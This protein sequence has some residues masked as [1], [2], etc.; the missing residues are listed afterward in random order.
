MGKRKWEGW[1]E[2]LGL[3]HWSSYHIR[4]FEPLVVCWLWHLLPVPPSPSWPPGTAVLITLSYPR[5]APW[6]DIPRAP[7]VIPPKLSPPQNISQML[8]LCGARTGAPQRFPPLLARFLS[9]SPPHPH[10]AGA[11]AP[12]T[13]A[14]A[15]VLSGLCPTFPLPPPLWASLRAALLGAAVDSDFHQDFDN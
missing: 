3:I 6:Q 5:E 4:G 9:I 13:A 8:T 12:Q 10:L 11:G 2:A 15:R 14:V 1:V 7:A